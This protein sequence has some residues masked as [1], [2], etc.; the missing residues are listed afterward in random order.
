MKKL[1]ILALLLL[2]GMV[3]NSYAQDDAEDARWSELPEYKRRQ[4]Q[5]QSEA[6]KRRNQ[7]RLDTLRTETRRPYG[8]DMVRTATKRPGAPARMARM[9]VELE[10]KE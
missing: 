3:G 1:H 2:G 7:R 4:R 8:Y 5:A 6:V 9:Q 10:E